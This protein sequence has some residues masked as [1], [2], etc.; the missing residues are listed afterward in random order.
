M[1]AD[2]GY[3]LHEYACGRCGKRRHSV[4]QLPAPVHPNQRRCTGTYD[5]PHGTAYMKVTE[6]D[7]VPRNPRP[8][9]AATNEAVHPAVHPTPDFSPLQ[10]PS[11]D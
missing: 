11:G 9:S 1:T 4:H 7:L 6:W 5:E 8:A 2:T 3:V 10:T